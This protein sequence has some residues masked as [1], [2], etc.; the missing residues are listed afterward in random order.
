[1]DA[2]RSRPRNA[3]AFRGLVVALLNVDAYTETDKSALDVGRRIF[4]TNGILLVGQARIEKD[5]GNAGEAMRL[6][7][8][9]LTEPYTLPDR[10]R[11]QVVALRNNWLFAWAQ[12]E[13]GDLIRDGEFD[14]AEAFLTE[15]LADETVTG[16]I[17]TLLGDMQKELPDL[18]RFHLAMEAGGAGRDAEAIAMLKALVDDPSTGE[19]TRRSAERLLQERGELPR[20]PAPVPN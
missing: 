11:S 19:R 20:A 7:S 5:S 12:A 9:S 15:R 6:L 4:P 3:E 1:M 2:L 10:M 8:Q 16:R 14:H 17:R 13:I 18:E